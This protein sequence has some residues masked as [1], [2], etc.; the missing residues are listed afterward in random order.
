MRRF[1]VVVVLGLLGFAAFKGVGALTGGGEASG[2][3]PATTQLGAGTRHGCS[4]DGHHDI[5][6]DHGDHTANTPTDGT[7]RDRTA[8]RGQPG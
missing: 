7:G 3:E 6:T 8:H 4:R 1:A 5:A 2:Q